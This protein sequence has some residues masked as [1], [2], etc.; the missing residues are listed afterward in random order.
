MTYLDVYKS[1]D[2][3]IVKGIDGEGRDSYEVAESAKKRFGCSISTVYYHIRRLKEDG[4][5]K[6]RS[7]REV[8]RGI[9]EAGKL[10]GRVADVKVET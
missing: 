2:E 9:K 8:L 10:S 7:G 6:A 5:L 1:L 3:Y 4:F